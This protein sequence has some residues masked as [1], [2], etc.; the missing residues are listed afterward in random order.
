MRLLQGGLRLGIH[1]LE[2]VWLEPSLALAVDK[3]EAS[4]LGF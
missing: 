1:C 2:I 4:V 3:G